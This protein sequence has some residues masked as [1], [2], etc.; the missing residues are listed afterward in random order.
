MGEVS[1]VI[2]NG[3]PGVEMVKPT[4]W[5]DE[6]GL[7][8]EVFRSR[9]VP[10][11]FTDEIQLN[12]S[13]T[14][15]GG[16]RGLHFHR[17]QSDWWI[18]VSGVIRAAVADL[19]EG[20]PGF[21]RTAVIELS[22]GEPVCLL[23]PPGVAHG[24]VALTDARLLYAVNRYYDGSDEQ[25]VAWD[26]PDLGIQWGI[27]DPVLSGRDRVNPRVGELFPGVS[28]RNRS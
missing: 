20:S 3:I 28:L 17:N 1:R 15:A 25:G 6:R 16:L 27:A 5:P 13:E 21:L 24:F 2:L 26:D 12:L 9:W 23:I 14:R 10:G 18:P 11:L 19:R 4:V 8:M 22:S 7:F